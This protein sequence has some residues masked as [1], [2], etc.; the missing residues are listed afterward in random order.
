MV[1][2][3]GNP[4]TKPYGLRRVWITPYTDTDG[5]I[6]ASTSYRFPLARTLAFAESEDFDTLDGDDKSAVAIQGKGATVDGSIEGGGLDLMTYSI[7]SGAQLIE[8]GLDPN[9]KR[10]VRKKGSDQRPYFRVEG[11]S[12]SNGGG[13]NVARIFRCKANG[14]IQ[15]DM[16][17]GTFMTPSI[18]FMG[19]P[20]PGDDGDYLYEIEFNQQKTTLGMTPVANPLPIPSNV[21]VGALTGTTAGLMWNALPAANSFLVQKS[22]DGGTTWTLQASGA[23]GAPAVPNTSLTG[24]SVSIAYKVRVAGVFGGVTGP[25]STPVSFTTP[26]S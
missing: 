16:K 4:D 18:D 12:I 10:T 21:T 6:L 14:K 1:A 11:Q 20:M 22:T 15:A 23:G 19:T 8:S 7:I 24:L 5:S 2:S 26:A 13:D 3:Q 25:Y 17:F 9:L